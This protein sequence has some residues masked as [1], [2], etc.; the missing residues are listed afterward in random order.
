LHGQ[1]HHRIR[2]SLVVC[3]R[4]PPPIRRN[5]NRT[6]LTDKPSSS[7]CKQRHRGEPV[8]GGKV[9]RRKRL[10][11]SQSAKSPGTFC[12]DYFRQL[13]QIPLRIVSCYQAFYLL[14]CFFGFRRLLPPLATSPLSA[15]DVGVHLSGLSRIFPAGRP[16]VYLESCGSL[17]LEAVTPPWFVGLVAHME[18][19][20]VFSLSGRRIHVWDRPCCTASWRDSSRLSFKQISTHSS[21]SSRP[22]FP[23][24]YAQHSGSVLLI[25]SLALSLPFVLTGRLKVITYTQPVFDH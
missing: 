2:H 6:T 16:L 14:S 3:K 23:L 17:S 18:R 1:G 10:S 5:M 13:A 11:G 12:C 8:D 22:L 19:R 7:A 24:L 21:P 20:C 4:P 15:G 9:S 25:L